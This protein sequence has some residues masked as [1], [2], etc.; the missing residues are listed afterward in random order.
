[1]PADY[2]QQLGK[3]FEHE[4]RLKALLARQAELNAALDL[5]KGERQVTPPDEAS[6]ELGG[7]AGTTLKRVVA[8]I[9]QPRGAGDFMVRYLPAP[10]RTFLHFL[11]VPQ[12]PFSRG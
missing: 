5:D 3:P 11:N 6:P 12:C 10:L 2:Q 1:M 9:V 4:S 8:P 7:D